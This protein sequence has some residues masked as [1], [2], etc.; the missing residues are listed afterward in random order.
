MKVPGEKQMSPAD[1]DVHWDVRIPL[2]D[3]IHLSAL[4]Y[5]PR[6]P[7]RQCPAIVT[8]TPYVAQTFH[9]IG[10]YFAARGY[11]FLSVDVR[12]RGNSEGVFTPCFNEAADGHDVVEWLAHQPYCNG[13][14]AMWGGS[15]AG[16][17]QWATAREHPPHLATIV[18]VASP[19]AGVD[20]PMRSNIPSP[21]LMQ[22]LTLVAGR[23]SQDKLF[24]NN[25]L[26]W[27]ARFRRL[28]E[29][30]VPFQ[31]FDALLGNPSAAFQEW[32]SHPEPDAYW[33][34]YNPTAEQYA[35]IS[36]PILTITG[37]Y[38]DDQPGALKHYREHLRRANGDARE[39]HYLIIGPWD[40]AGTR[41]P[42]P[43]FVGLR[44]GP[45]S[46]S[47]LPDLH[48]QWFAWTMQN[49]PKPAFLQKPVAYYLMGAEKWRYAD[50][51][52]EITS[53]YIPLYLHSTGNPTDVFHSGSLLET[54][55]PESEPDHYLYDP[56]DIGLAGLECLVDPESRVDQ[57]MVNASAGKHL[58]YHSAPFD[59][60][61]EISG[62]FKLS[63][64]IA[65]D[66]PDT[67]F[68]AAV[69]EIDPDGRALLMTDDRLR[70]RYRENARKPRL[71]RSTQPL[72][73]DF[74]GFLFTSRLIEKRHRLRLVI[75]PINS[76][77][78]QKNFNSGGVVSKES[79]SDARPVTVRLFH[80]EQ[81]PSALYVPLGRPES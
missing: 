54:P 58:V 38:D 3:G 34:S 59:A 31:R 26:F 80:S 16:F 21:D 20:F 28:F 49:G 24:C 27:G 40:H 46:L 43:E 41:T 53:H 29:L 1:V 70:A 15:Y 22:W 14:V 35:Q 63:A 23:T 71:L 42:M 12:G 56:R 39:R 65:I 19:Y 25:E 30:G 9:D 45:A 2:R 60:D 79:M 61:L 78:S 36:I 44:V 76:I 18:P 4:L 32:L 66:Q 81:Y 67:D 57:R 72:R 50:S 64:W 6:E 74:E 5:R 33:D 7:G 55:S 62:F 17:A 52:D 69:Y 10:L 75:G 8:L 13:Q 37:T 51:L 68:R 73:Y 11:P 77:Y 48:L 47:D